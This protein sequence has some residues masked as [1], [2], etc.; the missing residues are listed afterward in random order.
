[1]EASS[2]IRVSVFYLKVGI[3]E[4]ILT[5]NNRAKAPEF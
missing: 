2:E 5:D 3:H 4:L 1:M